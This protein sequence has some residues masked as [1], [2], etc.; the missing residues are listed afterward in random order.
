M[1][2]EDIVVQT[3]RTIDSVQPP[4]KRF[5][6]WERLE[7]IG[8]FF[9]GKSKE[10]KTMR[11]LVE[12]LK[13]AKIPYAIL[14]GMA[15][16]A[17][18]YERTTNDVDVLLTQD[19]FHEFCQW[20]VPRTYDRVPPH[21]RRFLDRR[22][23]VAF[24]ILVTGLFPG[25]GKPGP[26][27]FP[28]PSEVSESINKLRVVNLP[29]LIELKLAARRHRDFGDVVE[30]IRFNKL[31]ESFQTK[32]HRSVH[33]HFIECLEEKRRDDE[34]EARQDRML[35]QMMKKFPSGKKNKGRK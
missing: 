28:E 17:H 27:S 33:R 6:F 5:N 20:F 16:N 7:E 30:L 32:L 34:Y 15:V 23:K 19:G 31:D 25:S 21:P 18:K 13:K 14:G 26:I 29:T 11:R 35:E 22:H 12:N 4:L 24:D 1:R 10:H 8:M 9:K 3:S 2:S